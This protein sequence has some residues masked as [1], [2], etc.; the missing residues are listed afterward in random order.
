MEPI[1]LAAY[2]ALAAAAVGAAST[3]SQRN[4]QENFAE[5][6]AKLESQNATIQREQT[7][8]KEESLRKRVAQIIG[9][10]EAATAQSGGGFGGSSEDLMMQSS[11]NAEMD[12]LTTRYEGDLRARGFDINAAGERFSGSAAKRAGYAE[13]AGSILSG[14][15]NYGL[16]RGSNTNKTTNLRTDGPRY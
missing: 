12:I 10:Q 1:T 2:A 9:A 5:Y 4:T 7:V 11:L 8:S 6:N 3:V 13:A 14:V 16:A 15:A